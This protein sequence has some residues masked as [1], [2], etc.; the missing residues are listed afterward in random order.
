MKIVKNFKK[1]LRE[2]YFKIKFSSCLNKDLDLKLFRTKNTLLVV[3]HETSMTGAPL[4]LLN[5]LKKLKKRG[6]NIILITMEL[7]PL[8]KEFSECS[9]VFHFKNKKKG[10]L[11]LAK[12]RCDRCKNA[13]TN[14]VIAGEW[15]DLLTECGFRTVSLVH[16][17]PEVIRVREAE[18]AA[19]KVANLSDCV[20]FPSEFVREKFNTIARVNDKYKIITQGI[21]NKNILDVSKCQAR[22]AVNNKFFKTQVPIVL[23]VA[24]GNKRKGADIFLRLVDILKN[25]N[26]VWVGKI[27]PQILSVFLDGRDLKSISNLYLP[28]YIRGIEELNYFYLAAS[29]FAL[30][31]REEPFGTVVLEAMQAGTPV[32]AFEGAGGFVDVVHNG[33]TGFLVP[34]EDVM[35]MGKKII[36]I[37]GNP[38]LQLELELATKNT[39]KHFDFDSYID[40]IEEVIF[41]KL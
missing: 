13:L 29:V 35:S 25:I 28:G 17:L 39:A 38:K 3:S 11:F 26:F 6:W 18:Q 21:Y 31:S 7:G 34:F 2:Y 1:I 32:L 15:L 41:E 16:E 37:C 9:S 22:E 23:N 8:L 27:D 12:V 24:S 30:T 40:Q 10:Q 33:K 5:I 4:L 36:E 14:S 19:L 20:V